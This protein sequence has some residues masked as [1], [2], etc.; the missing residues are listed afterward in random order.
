MRELF[1]GLLAVIARFPELK[2]SL[3]AHTSGGVTKQTFALLIV[4]NQLDSCGELRCPLK[5]PLRS[6][7]LDCGFIRNLREV[8][9][10]LALSARKRG[11]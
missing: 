3:L 11:L 5:T 7:S 1:R 10:R 2:A 4:S 8:F 6:R 9:V